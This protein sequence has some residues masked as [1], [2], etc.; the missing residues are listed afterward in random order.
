MRNAVRMLRYLLT[1]R[2]Q[3]H[4]VG[5][6]VLLA[7]GAALEMVSVSTI[8]AFVTLLGAPQKLLQWLP[9]S[10]GARIPR[11]AS[12]ATLILYAAVA[13]VAISVVKNVCLAL[14]SLAQ[15]RYVFDRQASISTRLL[16]AYLHAPYTFH[17]QRNT[18]ELLRNANGE[19]TEVISSVVLPIFAL[20]LE[21]LTIVAIML[22][23]LV[24]E[25]MI[26]LLAFAMLAG[27]TAVFMRVI[28]TRMRVYGTEMHQRRTDMIRIVNEGLGGIKITKVLGRE[29]HFGD[30]YA[31]EAR[32]Y[33]EAGR[34]RQLAADLPRLY[35][36]SAAILG[37]LGVAALLLAQH[38]PAQSIIP[39]LSLFAVAVVRMVPS[40]NRVTGAVGTL[41]YGRHS[42]RTVYA[43]LAQLEG[44]GGARVVRERTGATT[45]EHGIRFDDV[46][47]RYPGAPR[48]SLHHVSLEIR[49]GATIGLVGPTGSGK[50][51]LVDL[52]LGLLSPTGGR[53]LTDGRDVHD[54]IRAWQDRVGYVPQ[55][56]YLTDDTIRRNVALG[57]ADDE[58]DDAAVARAVE[59]AQM[60]AFVASLP[61][62][63]ETIVGE[64]GV[65]LSGGQ[66]QRIG[67]A[68]ALYVDPEVLVLDEATS[69]LDGETERY[70]MEAVER[71]RGD[72]TIIMVAHRLTT[73]RGCDALFVLEAGRIVSVGSYEELGQRSPQFRRMTMVV[74]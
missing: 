43:D 35:L 9:P 55:D 69:S 73:V 67:I 46:S 29:R 7:C 30:A 17:L 27:T 48:P 6:L 72:R 1:R 28:R 26:S 36:E 24:R 13:L 8:P 25:P 40:F 53:I 34:F 15:S 47:F 51:T 2:E 12:D 62:G 74:G 42:L 52:V 58:I 70:V 50:T 37:V 10:L 31:S 11:G 5:L 23:L 4:T 54:D 56:V 33:A 44:E 39:V 68:R 21:G 60:T 63:I 45:F 22:V 18:A 71:L 64:R 14:L 20:A 16:R 3:A 59:A 32:E 49:K 57:I 61:D 38:R 41:R 65:R 19:A 66:R